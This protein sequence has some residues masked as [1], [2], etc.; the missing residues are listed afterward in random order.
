VISR[1]ISKPLPRDALKGAISACCIVNSE[2]DT[3]VVAEIELGKIAMQ[4]LLAAMLRAGS[5]NLNNLDKWK[6]CLNAA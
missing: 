4:M 1:S 2:P 6:F 3:I 5:G